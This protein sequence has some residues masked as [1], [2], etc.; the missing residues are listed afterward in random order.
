MCTC[1]VF[2]PLPVPL[3]CTMRPNTVNTLPLTIN[4]VSVLWSSEITDI[5][6]G[7]PD[8]IPTNVSGLPLTVPVPLSQASVD[9]IIVTSDSD[10]S[11][12]VGVQFLL[13]GMI[14]A[15]WKLEEL[16]KLGTSTSADLVV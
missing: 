13:E 4:E 7:S 8:S 5:T 14:V 1:F 2:M 3:P 15:A 11:V 6:E 16:F 9:V 10:K 12:I